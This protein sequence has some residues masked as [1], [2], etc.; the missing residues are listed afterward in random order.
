MDDQDNATRK[1]VPA[2][3]VL[4]EGDEGVD[5]ENDTRDEAT[6]SSVES[7]SD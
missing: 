5:A 4:A 2:I 3:T 7:S 6:S 1:K